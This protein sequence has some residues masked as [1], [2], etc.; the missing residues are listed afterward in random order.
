[1]RG[2]F[3]VSGEMEKGPLKEELGLAETPV[4]GSFAVLA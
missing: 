3:E 1:M 4:H 2:V